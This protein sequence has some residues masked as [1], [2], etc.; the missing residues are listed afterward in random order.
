MPYETPHILHDKPLGDDEKAHFHFDKFAIT[1]AR[2]AAS[3]DT[4][5]PVTVG[6]SGPWGAGKT[7]L[8][9]RTKSLLDDGDGQQLF[10][11]DSD[12]EKF[13]ECKTVWFDAW[14]YD[15]EDGL[16]VALVRV[17]LNAMRD[18]GLLNK[19]K[20]AW[21]NPEED[22]VDFV[23]MFINAFQFTFG[24]LSFQLDPQAH[25]T[26]SPFK[27]KAA[28]FDHFDE[29]FESLLNTWVGDEGALVVFI[30]DL[31]RCL[32]E[33]VVQ[34]LEAVK[35]FL[36]KPGC[37]FMLGA[38][39]RQ[40][41]KAVLVHY[42]DTE[43]MNLTEA[44]D[45]LEKIIQLR[46][47]IPPVQKNKMQALLD[48]KGVLVA[49]WGESWR[50]LIT[51]AEVNPR[52]VK[53]FVND[54]NLQWAML[55]NSGQAQDV[56]RHDFNSWQV[57]IRSAPEGFIERVREVLKDKD[58]RFQFIQ[59]AVQW[60]R[61]NEDLA[62]KFSDYAESLRLRR[63]LEELD[64]SD[65][66]NAVA[67]DSFVYLT[68]LPVLEE[69]E[70]REKAARGM[71]LG[72]KTGTSAHQIYT[73]EDM[74][75]V[76]IPA[77]KFIMGSLEDDDQAYSN[78]KPQH[79]VEITQDY[80]I[81][82]FPVTNAQYQTFVQDA[83][84]EPPSYW[85]NGQYPTDKADHPVVEVSWNDAVAYCKWLSRKTDKVYRLPTEAEWEKAARGEYGNIYP[86]GD[87][88]DSG[89][90][91]TEESGIGD[92]TPVGQYS[93]DGDSPYGCADMSGNVWEWCADWYVVGEYKR[94]V[95]GVVKDPQGPE[96]GDNRALRGGSW[97][98]YNRYARLSARYVNHPYLNWYYN[99]FRVFLLPS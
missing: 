85:D 68:A 79:T 54:L 60:A 50:T 80:Y 38:D 10:A 56:N 76:K 48:E 4:D 35:L 77:G 97:S 31:D 1:L 62:P 96:K 3:T 75:F 66:F 34:V 40:V 78:E 93:P 2:L 69:P 59:E 7:T 5:T 49:D 12:Q 61:G 81:G 41:Q 82:R 57:L 8:L 45:Y 47:E 43:L 11:N 13:R 67:L 18:D 22:E 52:K 89:K 58:L 99:G 16:L 39:L 95:D 24:G 51:G 23:S 83:N 25:T 6:I 91:N 26:E 21:E 32:P 94:R 86:W 74:E 19:F 17:I 73:F 63:V 90:C 33:K 29:A 37:V 88:W 71:E 64:F 70:Q 44:R 84:Q 42:E 98:Y 87:E 27:G 15:D 92:T 14:K 65:E 20:A 28:F 55:K 53:T 9:R 36:D 30:D 46:F 72:R